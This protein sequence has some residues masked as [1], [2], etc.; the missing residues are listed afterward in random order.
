M[1]F[2]YYAARKTRRR[3]HG[4]AQIEPACYG[5]LSTA[6]PH[7][8][9][10]SAVP[11]PR[12]AHPIR[13]GSPPTAVDVIGI[14]TT[15]VRHGDNQHAVAIDV[16]ET[17]G[18]PTPEEVY[19]LQAV[20]FVSTRVQR[21]LHRCGCRCRRRRCSRRRCWCRGRRRGWCGRR[22]RSGCRRWRRGWCGSSSR[23]WTG[24]FHS[25]RGTSAGAAAGHEPAGVEQASGRAAL[26]AYAVLRP[27][28]PRIGARIVDPHLL[29]DW[30][31][32]AAD[33]PQFIVLDEHASCLAGAARGGQRRNGAPSVRSRVIC[34][35][36][37]WRGPAAYHVDFT[38]EQHT[39]QVALTCGHRSAGGVAIGHWVVDIDVS[40]A[41]ADGIVTGDR[42]HQAVE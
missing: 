37:A 1:D 34:E 31:T 36:C 7:R 25:G 8:D 10:V 4:A 41:C 13:I 15:I 28:P 33:N 14:E 2:Q 20:H 11:S 23:A 29:V 26:V 3:L 32:Q 21:D 27:C 40:V 38:V 17:R 39:G 5:E 9:L 30:Q 6:K 16:D 42:V 35:L 18:R 24:R 12:Y 22:R 19:R